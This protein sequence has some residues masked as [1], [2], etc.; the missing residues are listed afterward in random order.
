VVSIASGTSSG[1]QPDVTC[2]K[3]GASNNVQPTV[4]DVVSS[5]RVQAGTGR[6]R[7]RRYRPT[8]IAMREPTV[9]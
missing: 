1:V 4:C 6:L 2:I 9:T 3:A 7:R 5:I 8:S